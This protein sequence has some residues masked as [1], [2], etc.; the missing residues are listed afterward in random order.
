MICSNEVE[1]VLN[2]YCVMGN[3]GELAGLLATLN[4]KKVVLFPAGKLTRMLLDDNKLDDVAFI[5]DNAIDM[6]GEYI[7]DIPVVSP[8]AIAS[9]TGNDLCIVV[10][11]PNLYHS[12][13]TQIKEYG[14]SDKWKTICC[15]W[16]SQYVKKFY[17]EYR[18][19]DRRRGS[20]KL[21]IVLSG[22]KQRLWDIVFKRIKLFTPD[23][24]DV[25][26]MSSGLF[27]DELD[28]ICTENSWSYLS[29][30]LNKLTLIQ[31][32][33]IKLHPNAKFIYK[34]DEDMFI[35][36]GFF[37]GLLDTFEKV[38]RESYYRVGLV[39]PIIPVNP[40]GNVRF[41]EKMELI[42]EY[43]S[44]FGKPYYDFATHFYDH[45]DETVYL[46]R[47]TIPIDATAKKFHDMPFSFYVCPHRF[48]IGAIMYKRKIWEE[49]G[50]FDV[51]NNNC[52]GVDE[53]QI[54]MLF[55]TTT[56]F[57][58]MVIAENVLA[59]HF[60]FG[61]AEDTASIYELFEQN[62]E[63]FDVPNAT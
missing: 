36:D 58:S 63:L 5:C 34:L 39:A 11:S 28:H 17:D 55:L 31:N 62:E 15:F 54:A 24:I 56:K 53:T 30:S 3:T 20:S 61:S 16:P 13:L 7:H 33:A 42:D 2:N 50:G 57:Y 43:T 52:I 25:C 35:C 45:T 37:Q 27:N 14:C 40:H 38:E 32:I 46:W 60:C 22:Y 23:D 8:K 41:L 4:V 9:E 10:T 59:G 51:A 29:T 18:F 44:L 12:F 48:S 49:L 19:I 47:K 6:Q 1:S 26:V 21:L